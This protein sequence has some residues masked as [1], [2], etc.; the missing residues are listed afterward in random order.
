VPLGLRSRMSCARV[1]AAHTL[2][3]ASHAE[4]AWPAGVPLAR[5]ASSDFEGVVSSEAPGR[6]PLPRA[7]GRPRGSARRLRG[8]A[9]CSAEQ[10]PSAGP[11]FATI[12]R[13]GRRKQPLGELPDPTRLVRED[14]QALDR[15]CGARALDESRATRSASYPE[16]APLRG[17]LGSRRSGCIW[18]QNRGFRRPSGAVSALVCSAP[19]GPWAPLRCKPAAPRTR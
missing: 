6:A 4:R 18:R 2:G 12:A 11:S 7:P 8:T 13:C 3:Q 1:I 17:S 9:F 10:K 16:P 19:R 15:R 14:G 5:R